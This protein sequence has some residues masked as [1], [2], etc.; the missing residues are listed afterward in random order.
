M[1]YGKEFWEVYLKNEIIL[2]VIKE[3]T[4]QKAHL[5]NYVKEIQV[6]SHS[7][8]HCKTVTQDY[9]AQKIERKTGALQLKSRRNIFAHIRSATKSMALTFL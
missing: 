8:R 6:L 2:K 4:E 9:H 3:L 1:N 7:Y 5:Q